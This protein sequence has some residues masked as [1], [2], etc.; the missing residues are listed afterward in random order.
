MDHRMYKKLLHG[1]PVW[2]VYLLRFW[3]QGSVLLMFTIVF[4]STY[5]S[6]QWYFGALGLALLAVLLLVAINA[7][8]RK[9]PQA[10]TLH[11]HAEPGKPSA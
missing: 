2:R 4:L 9:E 7:F 10:N 3:V 6:V 8:G 5:K 11:D 1:K